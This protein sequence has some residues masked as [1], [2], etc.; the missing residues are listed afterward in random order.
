MKKC[1]HCNKKF[2]SNEQ[3]NLFCSQNCREIET[4][5]RKNY[6]KKYYQEHKTE[7]NECNKKNHK[8]RLK[9]DI[10]F[11]VTHNL[12]T[13]IWSALKG[14]SKYTYT[15][16]LI[17]CSI[18]QLKQHLESKFTEGMSW[19][20]YDKWEIDH[21]RPCTSFD[22]RKPEEQLKCFNYINLQPLWMH[23]NRIKKDK[24]LLTT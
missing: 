13:R 17:G 14:I 10:K 4:E 23:D 22:L 24:L 11:K 2:I 8:N 7:M 21:I 3:E 20:N 15:E 16:E 9:T 5:Y 6:M 1:K 19:D 18:K 12:R